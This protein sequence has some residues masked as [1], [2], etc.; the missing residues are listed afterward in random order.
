MFEVVARR[1]LYLYLEGENSDALQISTGSSG[2]TDLGTRIFFFTCVTLRARI[3][4]RL[5]GR[6][7]HS[8]GIRSAEFV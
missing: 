8:R 6:C 2:G 1:N 3:G 5:E 4:T 7:L